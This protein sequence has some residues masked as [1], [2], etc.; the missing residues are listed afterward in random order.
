MNND[1]ANV[2]LPE[3]VDNSPMALIRIAIEKGVDPDKMTALYNLAERWEANQAAKAFAE[4][5]TGFQD[6]MQ[7]VIKSQEVRKSESKGGGKMYNFASF[8]DVMMAA[9]PLLKKYAIVVTFT[10]KPD[11]TKTAITCR[12]RVGTHFEETTITLGLPGIL[13]ANDSQQAGGA[14]SYG[15]RYAL[16][17]ALNIVTTGEDRD[18]QDQF[19]AIDSEQTKT[20]NTLLSTLYKRCIDAGYDEPRWEAWKVKFWQFCECTDMNDIRAETFAKAK[21]RLQQKIREMEAKK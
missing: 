10:T 6:D 17:A 12:I 5:L 21:D 14:L 7:P 16:C 2:H 3:T 19:Q 9:K 20:L 13:N 4:A 1:I 11:G 8:D 15:K 18:A